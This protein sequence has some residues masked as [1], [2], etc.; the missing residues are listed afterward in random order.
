MQNYVR[1]T[2]FLPSSVVPEVPEVRSPAGPLRLK[3]LA[4]VNVW[5][6]TESCDRPKFGQRPKASGFKV[7]K[8]RPTDNK[9]EKY[10]K[11]S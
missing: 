11:K 10:C 4:T 2:A 9:L 5:A 8:M 6:L 7:I 3:I 1:E